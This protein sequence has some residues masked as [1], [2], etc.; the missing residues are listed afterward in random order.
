MQDQSTAH[1]QQTVQTAPAKKKKNKKKKKN[2]NAAAMAEMDQQNQEMM[3]NPE[4]SPFDMFTQM[5]KDLSMNMGND[6]MPQTQD[7]LA[8]QL[9]HLLQNQIH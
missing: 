3:L 1:S 6:Q 2:P 5:A 4:Q 7:D 8:K 9:L